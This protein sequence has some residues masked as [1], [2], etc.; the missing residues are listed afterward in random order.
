MG[1]IKLFFSDEPEKELAGR[2]SLSQRTRLGQIFTPYAIAK[3][4]AQWVTARKSPASVLDP[5]LGLG[6]FLRCLL[7]DEENAGSKM[8]GYE[9]DAETAQA[10]QLLFT[11]N[12]YTHINFRNANFLKETWDEKFDAILCNPPYRKFRGLADKDEMV[13]A[14]EQHTGIKISRA[15]NLYIFFL[16][17]LIWQ[18]ADGGRAAVILPFEFLNADYGKPV[19]QL[20]LD[21][22]ILRK[23]LILGEALQPFDDVITTACI[24]CLERSPQDT[25]PEFIT[26]DTQQE[27][28]TIAANFNS[29]DGLHS[30]PDGKNRF[31]RTAGQKWHVPAHLHSVE[32]AAH[33]VPLSTFGKVM[34]GI[35]TGDNG[36]FV[37]TEDKREQFELDGIVSSPVWQNPVLRRTTCL[38][39]MIFPH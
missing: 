38:E 28:T 7:E 29:E 16:I 19:K 32:M 4:M 20:L 17:K 26:V 37:I 31:I 15:S 23:V 5:A 9:V 21:Q 18:L 39:M 11:F 27:L 3:C 14:V 10:T 6:I 35:A 24:L 33:F 30:Q 22:G 25:A 34:R 13:A 36:Y 1:K 2:T 12:G 8:T